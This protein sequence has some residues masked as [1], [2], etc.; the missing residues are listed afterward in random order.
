MSGLRSGFKM[1]HSRSFGSLQNCI[2]S[3]S[4]SSLAL[5]KSFVPS[6]LFK[7]LKD[8]LPQHFS[9]TSGTYGQDASTTFAV[10]EKFTAHFIHRWQFLLLKTQSGNLCKAPIRSLLNV[11]LIYNPRQRLDLALSG[12]V[13]GRPATLLESLDRPKIVVVLQGHDDKD[14]QY[15]VEPN[16]VLFIEGETTAGKKRFLRCIH[17]ASGLSKLLREDWTVVLSTRPDRIF[18][19]LYSIVKYVA[20]PFTTIIEFP[21]SLSVASIGDQKQQAVVATFLAKGEDRVAICTREHGKEIMMFALPETVDIEFEISKCNKE[22]YETLCMQSVN[23]LKQFNPSKVSYELLTS[24]VRE[25][26]PSDNDIQSAIYKSM[27]QE[28]ADHNSIVCPQSLHKYFPFK[29]ISTPHSTLQPSSLESRLTLL[30]QAVQGLFSE[31]QAI[32]ERCE[33]PKE[34]EP[35]Q[36]TH[37]AEAAF[38]MAV[39]EIHCY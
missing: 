1:K 26:S 32:K 27:A 4:N 6:D 34:K 21:K 8:Q 28:K 29:K 31:M 37:I 3:S 7:G 2:V 10:D 5:H 24:S 19:P 20:C 11:G 14:P 12:Y 13:F 38:D 39:G 15:T 9:V 30:E 36:E 25:R 17:V 16:D 18:V 23:Y 35:S 22:D 33:K